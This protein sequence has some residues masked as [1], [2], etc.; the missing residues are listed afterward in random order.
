M[1]SLKHLVVIAA[2]STAQLPAQTV[3]V[4]TFDKPSVVVAYYRS[5]AWSGTLKE[6]AA[7]MEAARKA[8]DTKKIAELASWGPASQ[9]LAHRQLA[10][11]APITNILEALTP[12]FPA[13]AEK[14][15]VTLIV[16]D[17][18]YANSAVQ[19]VDVTD[20]LLDW[21][22]AGDTTRKLVRDLRKQ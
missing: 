14:A 17:L 16:P 12:A 5:P 11:Q 9:D 6:K 2:L 7:E 22:K 18:P 19:T 10:G 13:I 8:G 15:Q 3:R 1:S 21:L 4:G 20:L